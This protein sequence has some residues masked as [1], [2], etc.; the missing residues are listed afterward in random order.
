MDADLWTSLD[1]NKI[2]K[3]I[4]SISHYGVWAGGSFG[5]AYSSVIPNED[6]HT[7]LGVKSGPFGGGGKSFIENGVGVTVE[8][9]GHAKM[10]V[11]NDLRVFCILDLSWNEHAI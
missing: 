8:D 1:V 10:S 4:F 5:S 3:N 9:G 6:V 2:V 11:L 7:M